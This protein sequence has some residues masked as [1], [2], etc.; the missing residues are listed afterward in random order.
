MDHKIRL[1]PCW[2]TDRDASFVRLRAQGGFLVSAEFSR[3][4]AI[5]ATIES[6]AGKPLHFL[7]PWQTIHVNGKKATIDNEGLVTMPTKPGQVFLFTEA[8]DH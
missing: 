8:N 6:Q 7:S 2:P 3:G 5:S 4:K 1:F